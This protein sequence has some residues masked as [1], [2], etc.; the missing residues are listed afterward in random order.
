MR[1]KPGYAIDDV[2]VAK[3]LIREHPWAT[4]VSATS[5]GPVASHYPF[6]LEEQDGGMQLVSHVGRPDE[7][8]H[9]LGRHELLVIFAGPHGYVSPGWYGAEPAVP[10]WDFAVV[11]TWGTPEILDRDE[12]LAVLER[13]VDHF[14]DELEHPHRMRADELNEAYVERIV[15]G[16]IGFRMPVTR[17]VGKDKMSQD[18]PPEI[19]ARVVA[20][21]R[22]PG[23][24][25]H[26]ELA[27]RILAREP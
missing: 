12:N 16:T 9:E 2:E 19:R 4:M 5:S 25:H 6:L 18:K 1:E 24:Y 8:L 13:L 27:D 23:P 22:E 26:P 14:E 3:E 7:V 15:R 17:W 20:A 21:L 10:T 11:H